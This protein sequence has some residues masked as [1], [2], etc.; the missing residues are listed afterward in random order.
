MVVPL[1]TCGIPTTFSWQA[2]IGLG[3]IVVLDSHKPGKASPVA[4]RKPVNISYDFVPPED[5]SAPKG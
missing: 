3:L 2:T 1:L 5:S 4:L